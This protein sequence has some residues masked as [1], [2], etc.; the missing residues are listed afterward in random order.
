M[1]VIFAVAVYIHGEADRTVIERFSKLS[2]YDSNTWLRNQWL[3][4]PTQQNPNDAWIIQEIIAEVKP[5][6]I[7][8]TGL[9]WAEVPF[10]GPWCC[11]R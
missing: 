1:G 3:G 4:I 2:Y 8:E 7:V 11:A 5:D 9:S 6:Y 10:C